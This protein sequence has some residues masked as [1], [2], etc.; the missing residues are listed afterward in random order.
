MPDCLRRHSTD[1]SLDSHQS[2][3]YSAAA[4][5]RRRTLQDM[6]AASRDNRLDTAHEAFLVILF[7]YSKFY[8]GLKGVHFVLE[9]GKRAPDTRATPTGGH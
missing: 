2:A 1:T 8:F 6:T 3:R 5:Q 9:E 4:L 7:M